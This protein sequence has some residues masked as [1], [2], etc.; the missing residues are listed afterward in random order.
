MSA[1]THPER[2][3]VHIASVTPGDAAPAPRINWYA[4]VAILLTA[5][6][7]GAMIGWFL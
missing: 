2:L 4:V 3:A 1:I 7:W 5:A 6:A